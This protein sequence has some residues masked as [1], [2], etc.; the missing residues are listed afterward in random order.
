[1]KTHNL[2]EKANQALTTQSQSDLEKSSELEQIHLQVQNLLSKLE[3]RERAF[4][5][6]QAM[7]HEKKTRYKRLC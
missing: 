7:M 5:D 1:M 4:K 2:L 3:D 6:L